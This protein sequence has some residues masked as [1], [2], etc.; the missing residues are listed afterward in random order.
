MKDAKHKWP[1]LDENLT[2]SEKQLEVIENLD[3]DVKLID[4]DTGVVEVK[5]SLPW[6][7]YVHRSSF[8][9]DRTINML[10]PNSLLKDE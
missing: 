8:L 9:P 1:E 5:I 4:C 7:M 10:L 3:I 6:G 2:S